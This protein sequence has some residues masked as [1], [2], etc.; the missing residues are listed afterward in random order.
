MITA[1]SPFEILRRKKTLNFSGQFISAYLA[2]N[3]GTGTAV[4]GTETAPRGLA[5]G[6]ST[7]NPE[8]LIPATDNNFVGFLTRR[9]VVGGLTPFERAIGGVVSATP[10]GLEAPFTDG[11]EVT[12]ELAQTIECEAGGAESYFVQSGTGAITTSTPVGTPLSFNNG[13]WYAAQST[14]TPR[15]NLT[16]NNLNSSDGTSQRIR[17]ELI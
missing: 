8:A 7:T 1:S 14:D 10:Q 5:L 16:A 13:L 2:A 6:T 17:V 4:A 12:A 3:S 11:L 9:V 15:G